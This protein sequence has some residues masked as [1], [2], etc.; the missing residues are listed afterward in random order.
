MAAWR[1]L[2]AVVMAPAASVKVWPV[3]RRAREGTVM[4][5]RA[6]VVVKK[7]LAE[8]DEGA[9]GGGERAGSCG[10]DTGGSGEGASCSW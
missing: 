5:G 4:V 1:V 10:E 9:G 2:N 3:V 7:T 8:V 6:S